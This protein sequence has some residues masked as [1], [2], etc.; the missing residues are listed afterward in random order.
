MK[1]YTREQ[2][3]ARPPKAWTIRKLPCDEAVIHW[4]GSKI[5]AGGTRAGLDEAPP[6]PKKPGGK[7]YQLWR[8]PNSPKVQRRN[9]SKVIRAYN[10]A[11]REYAQW[12]KQGVDVPANLVELEKSIV[13]G[14]QNFHMDGHGWS[15][16]GYHYIIFATGNVYCGRDYNRTGAHAYNANHTLGICHVM[17]PG[18]EPTPAM[19]EA[20]KEIRDKHGIK[21]YRG[22]RQ[23]P[24][25]A[26]ACPG[27]R[28]S[29]ILGLP[30]GY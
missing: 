8:D 18:D 5:T 27:D 4:S 21:R 28:L 19:L 2:W 29:V 17:G 12:E 26:T 10:K 7:W 11:R 6:F 13:R 16:I 14:F 15:D 23:V 22:H 1:V 20:S 9:I 3:G 30:V 25:N 24:G